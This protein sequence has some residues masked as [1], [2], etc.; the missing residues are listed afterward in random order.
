MIERV[1]KMR[2]RKRRT[3]SHILFVTPKL[4]WLSREDGF[5]EMSEPMRGGS[6]GEI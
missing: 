2:A 6:G 1:K 4:F 3:M 5:S